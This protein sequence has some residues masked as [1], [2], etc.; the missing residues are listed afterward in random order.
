MDPRRPSSPISLWRE[1]VH[2]L[3][4]PVFFW[5]LRR[6]AATLQKRI[7]AGGSGLIS[8][9]ITW[10][11][12]IR[13]H[14]MID[15]DPPAWDTPLEAC[16]RRVHIATLDTGNPHLTDCPLIAVQAEIDEPIFGPRAIAASVF[17]GGLTVPF[18]TAIPAGTFPNLSHLDTS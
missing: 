6:F 14:V 17:D 8:Y 5:N 10:W 9:E 3:F 7:A 15:P 4:W 11:G 13:I 16:A 2:P 18:Y 1:I 12:G